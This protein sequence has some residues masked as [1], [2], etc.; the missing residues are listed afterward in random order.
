MSVCD[1]DDR[2]GTPL[3]QIA[4][5]LRCE[6][7]V[8]SDTIT[9]AIV[10]L[11]IIGIVAVLI[12]LFRELYR[13]LNL[14]R[15]NNEK[16]NERLWDYL[17]QITLIFEILLFVSLLVADFR[18]NVLGGFDS[19]WFWVTVLVLVGA[20]IGRRKIRKKLKMNVSDK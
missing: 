18:D 17:L 15:T 13:T 6:L 4:K 3:Y 8:P 11:V 14:Y 12:V 2:G 5:S 7:G 10:A 16:F 9:Y 1:G 20:E 19:V